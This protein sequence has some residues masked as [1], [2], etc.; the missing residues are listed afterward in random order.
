MARAMG[1]TV[2]AMTRFWAQAQF[3]GSMAGRGY[4]LRADGTPAEPKP[5]E[6]LVFQPGGTPNFA[7]AA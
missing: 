1:N 6:L 7:R 4:Q 3:I 2:D 5:T